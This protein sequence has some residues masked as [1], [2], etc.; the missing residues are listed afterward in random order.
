MTSSF[1]PNSVV[2]QDRFPSRRA[3]EMPAIE[4]VVVASLVFD[5]PEVLPPQLTRL[6][7]NATERSYDL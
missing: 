2:G 1:T 4:P 7:N 6:I 5:F 3:L